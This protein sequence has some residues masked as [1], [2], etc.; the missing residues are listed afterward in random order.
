M[1]FVEVCKDF[2][3][4]TKMTFSLFC[5]GSEPRRPLKFMFGSICKRQ[6]IDSNAEESSYTFSSELSSLTSPAKGFEKVSK[7]LH[8]HSRSVAV[9]TTQ[10]GVL[11]QNSF[12][13]D[14]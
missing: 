7:F 12:L 2:L 8:A 3:V 4:L 5:S 11:R 10:K 9:T 6:T 13:I 14:G 1:T